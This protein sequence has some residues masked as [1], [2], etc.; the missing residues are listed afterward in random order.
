MPHNGISVRENFLKAARRQQPAW[1]PLDFGMSKGAMRQFHE[2]AGQD[3]DPC[4]YFKFDGA[5]LGNLFLLSLL[6]VPIIVVTHNRNEALSQW[7]LVGFSLSA[8]GVLHVPYH[9]TE[10]RALTQD[11]LPHLKMNAEVFAGRKKSDQ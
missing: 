11:Y 1:V 3:A 9:R 2:Q 7:M 4:E 8:L 6:F 5:W 10:S